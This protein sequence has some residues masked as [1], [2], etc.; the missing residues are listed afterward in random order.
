M[1]QL[2]MGGPA[3]VDGSGT[4]ALPACVLGVEKGW[5]GQEVARQALGFWWVMGQTQ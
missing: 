2:A 1:R 5:A 4:E 3:Q